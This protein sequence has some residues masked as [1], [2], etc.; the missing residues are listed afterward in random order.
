M[1]GHNRKWHMYKNQRHKK[2]RKSQCCRATG[3]Q[4]YIRQQ[5]I[6]FWE[7]NVQKSLV[8]GY[9]VK[10]FVSMTWDSLSYR[11]EFPPQGG[12][13]RDWIRKTMCLMYRS[14]SLFNQHNYLPLLNPC[15]ANKH[16]SPL[17]QGRLLCDKTEARFCESTTQTFQILSFVCGLSGSC[18]SKS[19]NNNLVYFKSLIVPDIV[20]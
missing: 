4:P 15:R 7:D 10:T 6:S 9:M 13:L 2:S 14:N 5:H 8:Y 11:V 1:T 20:L 18:N 17:L 12:R 16:L 3:K 19:Q